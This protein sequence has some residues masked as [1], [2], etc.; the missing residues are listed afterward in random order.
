MA[1]IDPSPLSMY[2]QFSDKQY[3]DISQLIS[4]RN[5]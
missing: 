1:L 3:L 5:G 4:V 2:S